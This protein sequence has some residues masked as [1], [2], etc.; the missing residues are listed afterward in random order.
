M[1]QGCVLWVCSGAVQWPAA[2][3]HYSGVD[4]P[5]RHGQTLSIESEEGTGLLT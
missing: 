5:L 1:F 4:S 2:Q 3:G